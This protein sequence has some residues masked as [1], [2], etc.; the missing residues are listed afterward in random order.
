MVDPSPFASPL[1]SAHVLIS[2]TV[3]GVGYRLS[4]RDAATARGLTGWVRNLPDGRVEAMFEGPREAVEA[5]IR[6]CDAGPPAAVVNDVA[7][8][9]QEPMGL[10]A[11]DIHR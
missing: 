4:T 6:W 5:M 3:Q 11:F 7:V 8:V 10:E 2:G 9:Y 1:T